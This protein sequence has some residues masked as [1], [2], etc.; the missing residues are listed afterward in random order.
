MQQRRRRP[1]QAQQ[2]QSE[3][4]KVLEKFRRQR[5]RERLTEAKR[6][7]GTRRASRSSAS[8]GGEQLQPSLGGEQR[9]RPSRGGASR[10]SAAAAE[11]AVPAM[12][13]ALPEAP[14]LQ[15]PVMTSPSGKPL[16]EAAPS[17][18]SS[19]APL[20]SRSRQGT[21]VWMP[22]DGGGLAVIREGERMGVR[23][24]SLLI[25]EA[26]EKRVAGGPAPLRRAFR[27]FDID[28]SGGID[29]D[30]LRGVLARRCNL[31]F[32][33]P[34][35]TKVFA[36]F[37]RDG[38]GEISYENFR[39]YVMNDVGGVDAR[40]SLDNLQT[41]SLNRMS[42]V[43][44]ENLMRR[45]MREKLTTVRHAMR[46]ADKAENGVSNEIGCLRLATMRHALA[47]CDMVMSDKLW[48][49]VSKSLTC[50]V[51]GRASIQ[52]FI[53]TFGP[54]NGADRN[55]LQAITEKQMPAS[56]A[57]EL[58][59]TKITERIEDG[60]AGLRRAF[61]YFDIVRLVAYPGVNPGVNPAANP[62]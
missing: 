52:D 27:F 62:A 54:G 50:D 18:R 2:S 43:Q 19:A 10:Q 59:R 23:E 47:R 25:R 44:E 30:E 20:R 45:I 3:Q 15:L 6:K 58:I 36:S 11:V 61:Q 46:G 14:P 55:L 29:R 39:R 37:D 34:L 21:G 40:T 28:S 42:L 56:K 48:A 8:G 57:I 12:M 31:A 38:S 9:R 24:A 5:D 33:E 49:K 41:Q 35:L 7:G 32:D 13:A 17:A 4:R 60:P 16:S 53:L 1:S 51:M 22:A 26:I